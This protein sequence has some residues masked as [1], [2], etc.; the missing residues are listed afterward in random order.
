MVRTIL[1]YNFLCY[2]FSDNR[3][4]HFTKILGIEYRSHNNSVNETFVFYNP[5]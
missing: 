2:A 3:A 5:L 1:R 4:I